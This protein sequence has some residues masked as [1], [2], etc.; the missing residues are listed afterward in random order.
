MQTILPKS[1]LNVAYKE[2]QILPIKKIIYL[3]QAKLGYKLCNDMLPKK[4]TEI[5]LT[6]QSI[7]KRHH[8]NTRKKHIP[9]RPPASSS[10]YQKSYLY[11]VITSY[12]AIPAEISDINSLQLFVVSCKKYLQNND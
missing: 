3:E 6:D 8:Y 12:S 10:T 4:L 1:E 11:N 9:N 2:L 5:L 7:K